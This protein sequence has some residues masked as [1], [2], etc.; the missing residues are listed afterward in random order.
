MDAQ[1]VA[2]IKTKLDQV[3]IEE[4]VAIPLAIES[5][6]R[7][8]GFPSPDSDYDCRFIY[9]RG[10]K[11]NTALF[12]PRDVIEL[13]LTP[14]FDV[15][16]WDLRKAIKLLLKGNAVVIEWMQS[17][18]AYREDREFRAALLSLANEIVDRELVMNHYFHLLGSTLQ[19]H[20]VSD[21][22]A[23]IK[24]IFYALRPALALRQMRVQSNT[25]YPEMKMQVIA[26]HSDLSKSLLR[27]IDDLVAE[28]AETRET[29]KA[30]APSE[31]MLFIKEEFDSFVP[32]RASRKAERI[33]K[34]EEVFHEMQSRWQPS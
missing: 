9:L 11:H 27:I 6:S 20:F 3:C 21:E 7:A 17:P 1:I 8:W 22:P 34:A 24:K 13:P 2:E 26:K 12:P 18:I 14:I 28:K 25:I 29:G 10:L 16:G 23:S 4:N 32:A 31:I 15:N 33:A 30:V 19:R 5:G